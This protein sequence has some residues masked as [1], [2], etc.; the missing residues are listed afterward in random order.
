MSQENVEIVRRAIDG[1]VSADYI[2]VGH[3]W[4]VRDGQIV[5]GEGYGSR[6]QALE[7]VGLR[8]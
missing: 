2:R 8:E 4:T 3:L 6:K 1:F 7:A 5:R